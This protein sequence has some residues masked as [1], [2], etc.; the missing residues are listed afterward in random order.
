MAYGCCIYL[1]CTD[2]VGIHHTNLICAKSKVTL[3]LPR[4]ELC[5]AL[6]LTRLANNL[7]PKLQLKIIE[8]YFWT[9]SKIVFGV[10]RLIVDEMEKRLFCC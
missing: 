8:Q 10:D 7:I 4:L 3:S 5:A 9:D 6:L 2:D 1:S